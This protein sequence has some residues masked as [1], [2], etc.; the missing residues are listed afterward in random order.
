MNKS[1]FF[2]TQSLFREWL[3]NNH[4][5]E[6]ELFVGYYKVKSGYPSMTWSE[7]VDQ[8]LCFGWIDGVRRSMDED[9]YQIRFTPRRKTSVWS[10]VNLEK[11]KNLTKKGLMQ[12]AGIE[13]F[14]NRKDSN[15]TDYA[16]TKKDLNLPNEFES[17]FKKNKKAWDYFNSLAPSYK[18]LS[19][20]WV[21][22]AVQDKTKTKRLN[23]LIASSELGTN[24]WKDSKYKKKG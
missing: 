17:L 19:I 18:K 9:S 22:S 20:H 16:F 13:I 1:M 10:P 8:A 21:I 24:K 15:P 3:E 12:K 23:E 6:T 11:I 4:N 14:K 7:S 2:P 5:K